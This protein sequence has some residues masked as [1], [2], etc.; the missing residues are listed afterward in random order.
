MGAKS[1]LL[2]D[3]CMNGLPAL[4]Q[5]IFV[6]A[7][8]Y[9]DSAS[10]CAIFSTYDLHRIRYKAPDAELWRNTY[11]REYWTKDTWII[12]IHRR[13]ECHWVLAVLYLQRR[14]V[15][16]FDSLAGKAA[17]RQDIQVM[18]TLVN[19]SLNLKVFTRVYPSSS[20]DWW[21]WPIASDIQCS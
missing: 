8:Q 21:N 14:E 18:L 20:P 13:S 5:E 10:R 6:A 11:R 3:G 15:H 17:W 9:Q 4:L 2:N 16:I 12:P 19:L 7:P 1:G